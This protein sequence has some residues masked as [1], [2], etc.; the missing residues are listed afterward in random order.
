MV[1]GTEDTDDRRVH[2]SGHGEAETDS[3]GQDDAS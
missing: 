1:A 2:E 3:F